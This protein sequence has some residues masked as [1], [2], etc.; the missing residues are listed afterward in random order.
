MLRNMEA[1]QKKLYEQGLLSPYPLAQTEALLG[2]KPGALRLLAK[3]YEKHD[4]LTVNAGTD[5][6]LNSLRGEPAYRE[7]LARLTFPAPN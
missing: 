7:L 1:A 4:E 2:N 5:P 6:L 3:A